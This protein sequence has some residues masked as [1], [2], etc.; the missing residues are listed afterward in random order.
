MERTFGIIN[1]NDSRTET[2]LNVANKLLESGCTK[3]V[4]IFTKQPL[5]ISKN[6]NVNNNVINVV[7]SNDIVNRAQAKNFALTYFFNQPDEIEW[8]DIL[9][10]NIQIVE[11]PKATLEELERTLDL[12]DVGIWFGT[13]CDKCNYI[14]NKYCP[15]LTVN[16]KDSEYLKLGIAEKLLFTTNANTAWTMF[17]KRRMKLEDCLFSNDY[18]I[19]MFYIIEFIASRRNNKKKGQIWYMNIYPTIEAEHKMYKYVDGYTLDPQTYDNKKM[20]E[21]NKIFQAKNIS[22][23]ADSNIDLVLE[24]IYDILDAKLKKLNKKEQQ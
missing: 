16:F 10:D 12:L 19:P 11:E 24:N 8:I 23:I 18:N 2:A 4:V 3:E 9:E 22:S 15:R 5:V 20:I 6:E 17:N 7:F 14:Y 21:E 13:A 1:Y